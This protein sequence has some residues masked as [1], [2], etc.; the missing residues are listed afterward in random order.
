MNN[1]TELP[2]AKSVGD[3]ERTDGTFRVTGT[4]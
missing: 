4:L 1:V 2:W 3:G